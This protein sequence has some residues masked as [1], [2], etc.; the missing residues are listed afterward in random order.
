M[1]FIDIKTSAKLTECGKKELYAKC[2]ELIS[3][4]PGKSEAWLMI[5]ISDGCDMAFRGDSES[6]CAMIEVKIFGK[7]QSAYYDKFTKEM[8]D[9][10]ASVSGVSKDRIYVRYDE[11]SLWG[12]NGENF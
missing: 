12:W 1:P 6:A 10:F 8:T 3:I 11:C 9:F 4:F 7:S 5:N 2:G